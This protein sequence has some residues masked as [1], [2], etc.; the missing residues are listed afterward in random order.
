MGGAP[1]NT[2]RSTL[3]ESVHAATFST[4][5]DSAIMVFV[6]YRFE[7][8]S[9][10]H[11]AAARNQAEAKIKIPVVLGHDMECHSGRS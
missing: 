7:T 8:L 2:R 3:Q 5:I 11:T 1:L 10:G 6:V 9:V 4:F